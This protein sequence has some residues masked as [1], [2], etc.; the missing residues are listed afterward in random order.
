MSKSQL[1]IISFIGVFIACIMLGYLGMRNYKVSVEK[2][3]TNKCIEEIT[4]IVLI[5]K[6][7]FRNQNSYGNLDYNE[8]VKLNLFPSSMLKNN[9]GEAMHSYKGGVDIYYSSISKEKE[10][11]AFEVSFQ[12]LSSYA[13]E[14]LIQVDFN[15]YGGDI[16]IAVGGYST[17][18]PSGT[19]SEIYLDTK[20]RDI[21]NKNVFIASE[22][23]YIPQEQLENVCNCQK[24]TC[25]VIWKFR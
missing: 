25:T 16:L 10:N 21:N 12:G 24:N 9:Y 15:A 4:K 20:Q 7:R 2:L 17:S 3:K 1:K 23:K 19:L 11:S 8:A 6:E 22:I 13:C 5:T 14:K 18:M